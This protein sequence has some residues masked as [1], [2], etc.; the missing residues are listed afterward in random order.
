MAT[1]TASRKTFWTTAR[2]ERL[3]LWHSR[4]GNDYKRIAAKLKTTNHAVYKKLGRM[5]RLNAEWAADYR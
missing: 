3:V 4:F 5:G 1:Q 2:E